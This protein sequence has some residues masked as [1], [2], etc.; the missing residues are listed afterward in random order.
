MVEERR[1]GRW[2]AGNVGGGWW[3]GRQGGRHGMGPAVVVRVWARIILSHAQE[4]P[5][6]EMFN[7]PGR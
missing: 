2:H 6:P 3:G 5:A 1:N 7:Q 4:V